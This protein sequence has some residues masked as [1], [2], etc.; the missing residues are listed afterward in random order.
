MS[1]LLSK[2]SIA[3][4]EHV[5]ANTQKTKIKRELRFY[6]TLFTLGT[7]S[8]SCTV[9]SALKMFAKSSNERPFEVG[10]ATFGRRMV[11][12]SFFP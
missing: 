12:V 3:A 8:D 11:V 7:T 1:K 9:E 4:D 2:A 10:S 6:L 5:A